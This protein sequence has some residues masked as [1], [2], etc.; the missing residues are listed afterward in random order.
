MRTQ[1]LPPRDGVKPTTLIEVARLAGVSTATVNRVLKKT[2]YV[3]AETRARIEQAIKTTRYRPNALARELRKQRSM[4]VGHIVSAITANPFFANVARGAEEA[5]LDRGFRTLLFNHNGS[6]DRE[7]QGVERF[8]ERRV[9]A[10]LFTVAAARDDVAMLMEAN[11]PVVQI[12]RTA[13]AT[14][15]SVT[16][17]KTVGALQAMRHL[18]ELGHRRIAFVGGD[19]ALVYHGDA[20]MRAVEDERLAAYRQGL[21]AA[22]LSWNPDYVRLGH[23]Y[24]HEDGAGVHGYQHMKALFAGREWP[25]AIFATC[26]ILAAG[27]L[28]AIYEAGLRVP[29]DISVVGFDDT[30]AI[31]LAPRLTTVAQPMEELGRE[32]FALA[33]AQIEGDVEPTSVRLPSRLVIRDSVGPARAADQARRARG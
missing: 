8:I 16:V 19:P 6:P 9:D 15:P 27:V 13:L 2:G 24:R 5:A 12:E 23:Y 7:R 20:V 32:G 30:L 28:Q 3:S 4:T 31:N 33:L 18:I 1:S 17:D 14:A 26:D 10:V 21:Q 29:E 11:I 22:G 25:T